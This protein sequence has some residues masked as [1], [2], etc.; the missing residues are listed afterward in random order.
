MLSRCQMSSY[1]TGWVH[2]TGWNNSYI[3][4][5]LWF[6]SI[7]SSSSSSTTS[8]DQFVVDTRMVRGNYGEMKQWCVML[9]F[10]PA[11]PVQPWVAITCA[12]SEVVLFMPEIVIALLY[13]GARV[14]HFSCPS[15]ISSPPP[16]SS[17][18]CSLCYHLPSPQFSPE[19]TL[20]LPWPSKTAC[21]LSA[22][23][24]VIRF[25]SSCRDLKSI[26]S[27]RN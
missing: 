20:S 4:E 6:K 10:C 9:M 13:V 23:I 7:V 19:L 22:L 24:R 16:F 14:S 3:S 15:L 18:L 11:T 25:G 1:L 17:V 21:H 8:A 2:F 12:L 26:V 5:D 27:S